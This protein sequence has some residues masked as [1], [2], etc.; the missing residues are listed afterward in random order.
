LLT[1][2]AD[3]PLRILYVGPLPPARGGS[4]TVARLLLRG[5]HARG[6]VVNGL[7]ALP[8]SPGGLRLGARPP[9]A[10][11]ERSIRRYPVPMLSS[12]LERGSSDAAYRDAERR[13]IAR[14]LPALL[15]TGRPDVVLIGR[16]SLAWHVPDIV[17]MH[18][19]PS[20]LQVHGGMT[21][22]G[23]LG[24]NGDDFATLRARMQ[25]VDVV[26]A[27]AH[28]IAAALRSLGLPRVVVIQNPVDL[29]SFVPRRASTALRRRL[30]IP[31]GAAVMLHA[32]NL[33]GLKRPL[34]IVDAAALA[35]E[36][37]A[38]LCFLIV[39]DGPLRRAAEAAV[40]RRALQ[41]AFR[42]AGWVDHG[43]MPD[44]IN[45]ADGVLLP[46]ER[47]GQSLVCLETQA[48]GRVVIASDV[49]AAR[50]LI[51]HRQ[52]GLLFRLGDVEDLAATILLT[53]RDVGLRAAV[54][55]RARACA[56]SHATEHVVAAYE[57]VLRRAAALR[58]G[59]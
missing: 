35:L 3:A 4:E 14:R 48:C 53:A 52:T 26:V 57:G 19:V 33:T 2:V 31:D 16:E 54:G 17:R 8:A 32:S 28:H 10:D 55:A 46:S 13:E 37:D 5:L 49:P 29:R 40:A 11:V 23:L 24:G 12:L 22:A 9:R 42:F 30:R 38:R 15:R 1:N 21:L 56:A 27:V 58:R 59:A 44:Y 39:G 36:R 25:S 51:V 43:R 34:D 6:A 47:E 41:R 50:E 20:V 18:D 7:A 45:L